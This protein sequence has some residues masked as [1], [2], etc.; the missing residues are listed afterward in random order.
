MKMKSPV[1]IYAMCGGNGSGKTT[2]ALKISQE[3]DAAFFSLDKTIKEF[4]QPIQSF[5]DYE[6]Y[7]SKALDIISS[8]AIQVLKTGRSVVLDWGGGLSSRS[9]LKHIADSA[10]AAIEI[11]YLEVPKEERRRRVQ[12]RNLEKQKDVYFWNMSDE[13]FDRHNKENHSPL[14]ED[15][16]K[17]VKI[18]N[19]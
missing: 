12:K 19:I 18:K 9:W 17:I 16:I 6:S 3:K 15:G 13:E 10:G 8:Q 4:N 1:T 2:F 7:M 14:E 11:Y 5:E